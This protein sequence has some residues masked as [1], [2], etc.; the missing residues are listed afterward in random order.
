[1]V[2]TVASV[3]LIF[4]AFAFFNVSASVVDL[5]QPTVRMNKACGAQCNFRLCKVDAENSLA[6]VGR[7]ILLRDS[8]IAIPPYIC[9]EDVEIGSLIQTGEARVQ[10]IKG[11]SKLVRISK[12]NPTGLSDKFPRNYFFAANINFPVLPNRKGIARRGN[13]GNQDDFSDDLCVLLPI[14]KYQTVNKKGK[15]TTISKTG[16]ND[17]VSFRTI[18]PF[19]VIEMTWGS[20]DDYDIFVTEPDGNVISFK[21]PRSSKTGGRL[22]NDNVGA[23]GVAEVGKEQVRYLKSDNALKGKYSVV[24]R[25]KKNCGT[26]SRWTLFA[27]SEGRV[28]F[29]REGVS[30]KDKNQIVVRGEF[31][32]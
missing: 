3:V 6:S 26:P 13:S 22:I 24:V 28:V 4:A 32:I 2:S 5:D 29:G 25:H 1:M 19:L 20:A 8:G 23:C 27:I 15:T 21:K 31:T 10:P 30:N 18:A 9:R 17:C 12:Y 14:T 16:K 7:R 11:R